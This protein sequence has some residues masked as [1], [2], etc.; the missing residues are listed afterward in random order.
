MPQK[1]HISI[2]RTLLI[3]GY[4]AFFVVQVYCNIGGI[5]SCFKDRTFRAVKTQR[6]IQK[7]IKARNS[8]DHEHIKVLVN[9]RFHPE[10]T[11]AVAFSLST[12][13]PVYVST[14][15]FN[16]PEAHWHIAAMLTQSLRAP[17]ALAC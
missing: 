9:K 8:A 10:N 11:L 13:L 4:W 3:A 6:G 1:A 12:P 17:P 7:Q 16:I 14:G 2:S 5:Q 15:I